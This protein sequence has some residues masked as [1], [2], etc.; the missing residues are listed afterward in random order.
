MKIFSA[1]RKTCCLK[2]KVT[3]KVQKKYLLLILVDNDITWHFDVQ[4]L[5]TMTDVK[6][7]FKNI[8]QNNLM[9]TLLPWMEMGTSFI[10]FI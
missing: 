9:K 10:I 5:S 2:V 6:W 7:K 8:L 3:A 1:V 4:R